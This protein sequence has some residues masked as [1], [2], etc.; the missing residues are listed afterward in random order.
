MDRHEIQILFTSITYHLRHQWD[1]EGRRIWWDL[2]PGHENDLRGLVG[3]WE[4][5]P[6]SDGG[7]SA[8]MARGAMLGL[9][10][11]S[12]SKRQLR[13]RTFGPRWQRFMSGSIAKLEVTNDG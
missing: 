4:L 6:L 3:Y 13:G 12:A 5:Y 8:F 1:E 9:R 10:S 11:Q 2:S 7:H